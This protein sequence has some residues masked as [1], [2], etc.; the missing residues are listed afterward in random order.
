MFDQRLPQVRNQLLEA[1]H[2]VSLCFNIDSAEEIDIIAA[3][4]F[5]TRI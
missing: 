3:V 1:K 2:A 4:D 5:L